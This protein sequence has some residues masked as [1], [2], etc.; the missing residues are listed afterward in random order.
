MN[1]LIID[2]PVNGHKEYLIQDQV[3]IHVQEKAINDILKAFHPESVID[4]VNLF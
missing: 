3:A 2:C 4:I 1:K